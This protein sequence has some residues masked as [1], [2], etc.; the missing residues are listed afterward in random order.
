[1]FNLIFFYHCIIRVQ[2]DTASVNISVIDVNEW[3]PRFRFPHYEF[4]VDVAGAAPHL[5]RDFAYV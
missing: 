3:E 4:R 1:M 2:N 5:R